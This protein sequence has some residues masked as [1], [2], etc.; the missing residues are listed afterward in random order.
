MSRNVRPRVLNGGLQRP[1]MLVGPIISDYVA[2]P[3]WF[4]AGLASAES[5]TPM[6]FIRDMDMCRSK[7]IQTYLVWQ[8]IRYLS[9]F[10]SRTRAGREFFILRSGSFRF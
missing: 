1:L 7:D 8:L 6:N 10:G 5:P 4:S 3:I 9:I 2:N